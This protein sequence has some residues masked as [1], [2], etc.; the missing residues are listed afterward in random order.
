MSHRLSAAGV[1]DFLLKLYGAAQ[2]ESAALF[3]EFAIDEL[4][5][6]V[7]FDMALFGL[8]RAV[9]AGQ[10]AGGVECTWTHVHR[11]PRDMIEEWLSICSGDD[12][13]KNMM[14]DVGRARS[15]HVPTAFSKKEDA[16]ILDFALRTRHINLM[17]IANNY[18]PQGFCGAFSIRRADTRWRFREEESALTQML[19]P[20][21]WEAIRINRAVMASKVERASSEPIKGICICDDRGLIIF[22][23]PAF[24]R[25]CRSIFRGHDGYRLSTPLDQAFLQERKARWEEGRMQFSCRPV[26]QLR[27]IAVT[28]NTGMEKL[29]VR[30]SEVARFF[31]TG[32]THA[33]IADELQIAG[34]TV[35][36]QLESVY[37]KLNINNK[38]DLS[39]LVH[40]ARG[41]RV[42]KVLSALEEATR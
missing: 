24:E 18:G 36:R 42:E 41:T 38:A 10:D 30:E 23:D 22:Q 11:E 17:A 20:H 29:S 21:L 1:A 16:L 12:V 5:R 13:L 9:P 25:L 39:F 15:Y 28:L 40:A 2:E 7:D 35:R 33:E 34:S 6:F 4:K 37:R 27:F 26:A 3:P 19:A 31:G 8:I 14:A 32:L